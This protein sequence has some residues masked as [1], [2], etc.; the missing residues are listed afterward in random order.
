MNCHPAA[1]LRCS[2]LVPG[3]LDFCACVCVQRNQKAEVMIHI[4]SQDPSYNQYFC[5][6]FIVHE[7]VC[8]A[9]T[10]LSFSNRWLGA[11]AHSLGLANLSRSVDKLRR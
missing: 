4:F 11:G 10:L 5:T 7:V 9:L 2:G 6:F 8:E 3:E 1:L